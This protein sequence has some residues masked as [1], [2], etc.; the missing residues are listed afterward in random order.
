VTFH[1]DPVRPVLIADSEPDFGARWLLVVLDCSLLRHR[2]TDC[3]SLVRYQKRGRSA[4]WALSE[5]AR[6]RIYP[7]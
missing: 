4:V 7:G 1:D 6:P 5:V 3:H 2:R